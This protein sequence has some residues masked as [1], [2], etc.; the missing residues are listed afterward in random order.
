MVLKPGNTVDSADDN[1]KKKKPKTMTGFQPH[2]S[3]WSE[4]QA[5]VP[6]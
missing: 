3:L 2:E 6:S 5:P 1:L 4:D